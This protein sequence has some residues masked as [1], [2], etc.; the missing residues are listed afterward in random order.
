[1]QSNVLASRPVT[2]LA[3]DAQHQ[4]ALAVSIHRRRHPLERAGMT[5]KTTRNNGFVEMRR[6]IRIAGAVHPTV[7]FRPIGNRQL[8]ELVAF[9][10][11][12]ALPFS[13]YAGHDIDALSA[14]YLLPFAWFLDSTLKVAIGASRHL[15]M[16]VRV[17][18]PH[19]VRVRAEAPLHR[20]R[21]RPTR[22]PVMSSVYICLGFFLVARAAGFVSNEVAARRRL[23]LRGGARG[24][25]RLA[26][27]LRSRHHHKK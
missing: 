15:E 8:K 1:M 16:K 23:P 20:A 12:I 4:T 3:S 19:H 22:R 6:A 9:P 27:F 10:E 13:R 7:G 11:Q 18:C 14:R 25:R 2:L 17:G 21:T 24:L 26:G 5:L